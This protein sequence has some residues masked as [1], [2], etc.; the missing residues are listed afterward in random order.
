M[1]KSLLRALNVR[2]KRRWSIHGLHSS[3]SP[4]VFSFLYN[5]MWSTDSRS[6]AALFFNSRWFI[7][8]YSWWMNDFPGIKPNWPS[9][10]RLF[11]G[12]IAAASEAEDFQWYWQCCWEDTSVWPQV[13]P[14]SLEIR[15]IWN[16]NHCSVKAVSAEKRF[17]I[18]LK[19]YPEW[20][21]FIW[22]SQILFETLSPGALPD[23]RWVET[24]IIVGDNWNDSV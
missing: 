5:S 21:D 8:I 9:V 23:I 15:L 17:E 19:L 22:I 10:I 18:L 1:L 11:L 12:F 7:T 3:R 2:L 16:W 24:N 4:L 20:I 6:I 13:S 14:E